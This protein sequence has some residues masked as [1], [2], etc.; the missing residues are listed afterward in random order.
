MLQIFTIYMHP[1]EAP[2]NTLYLAVKF[3][4]LV[5]HKL[6]VDEEKGKNRL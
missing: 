3:N 5:L 4:S 2:P 6:L 1:K